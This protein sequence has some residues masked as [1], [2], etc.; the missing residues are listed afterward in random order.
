MKLIERIIKPEYLYQP[1][2]ALRRICQTFQPQPETVNVP[3]PW[4][5]GMTVRPSEDLGRALW[6]LGVYDLP[7]S[8]AIWRLIDR[9]E[10]AIDVG[11]NIGYATGLMASRSG[12]QGTV[13]AFE[14]H[15]KLFNELV[16]NVSNWRNNAISEIR[17]FELALS[18][19][20]GRAFLCE[21]TNFEKNRGTAKIT[22]TPTSVA[23]HTARLD[24]VCGLHPVGL[25][26][27]DVEGHEFGVMEGGRR[28]LQA[29]AIRDVVFEEHSR[30]F[31]SAV[32]NL[33]AGLGYAIFALTRSV[34]GPLLV[35]DGKRYK[36]A[37][38]YLPPNFL[39]TCDPK[40]VQRQR[41]AGFARTLMQWILL[42][43]T[44]LLVTFSL[45]RRSSIAGPQRN[46]EGW[47]FLRHVT[48]EYSAGIFT[49]YFRR[50]CWRPVPRNPAAPPHSDS[51]DHWVS[52]LMGSLLLLFYTGAED[53]MAASKPRW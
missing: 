53:S 51:T 44:A 4:K 27:V 8:E 20:S 32:A 34:N 19:K 15:P 21:G 9:G 11:A 1:R 6:R 2:Q 41:M 37:A 49:F 5:L 7:L 13:F 45:T 24:D 48:S 39:A 50:S 28:L 23:I 46:T 14:P 18:S 30:S 33:L 25:L 47:L 36:T 12:A 38:S 10:T 17:A 3:L 16:S 35:P 31:T 29:R 43:L 22:Q 52:C 42:F 40:R 26:K